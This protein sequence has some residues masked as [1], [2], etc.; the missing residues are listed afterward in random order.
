MYY[1]KEKILNYDYAKNKDQ[2]RMPLTER[3][4]IFLPFRASIFLPFAA[5]SEFDEEL[6]KVRVAKQ[7]SNNS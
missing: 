3:A 7:K 5:L 6:K 4:S 2:F 1:S